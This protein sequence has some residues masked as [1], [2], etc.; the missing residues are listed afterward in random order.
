LKDLQANQKNIF[1]HKLF[2][3]GGLLLVIVFLFLLNF[4]SET[5]F[6]RPSSIHQWRQAD[7]LSIAK[8]YYE[9]GMH[10]FSPK[11]HSFLAPE[12]KAV[13]EFPLINYTVALLWK[14]FG[15]HE[16]IYRL[17]NYFIYLI[18]IFTLFNT[19]LRFFTSTPS[20][21]LYFVLS[22]LLTSPLLVYY[23]LNFL[24]DVP[25]LSF[26][27]LAFCFLFWFYQTKKISYFYLSLLFGTLAILLKASALMGLVMLSFVSII[28]LLKL[29]SFF[30]LEKLFHRKV[31]PSLLIPLSILLVYKWYTFALHYCAFDNGVFL[32]TVAPVWKMKE[33]AI[34][35]ILRQLF[36][37]L[38]PTFLNRPMFTLFFCCVLF[39]AFNLKKV[40]GLLRYSF[41]F[42]GLFFVLFIL[43]FFQVFTVHDYYLINLFIFVIVTLFCL[44][45]IM[46]QLDFKPNRYLKFT[47]PIL[48]IFNAFYAA[49]EYRLKTI[50]DD[51]LCAWY[52]FISKDE[53]NGASY[54]FWSYERTLK[55]FEDIQTDLRKLG[56]QRKDIFVNV[57]DESPNVSLYFVDQKGYTFSYDH[58]SRDSLC[59]E[60]LMGRKIQ[61]LAFTDTSLLNE[62]AFTRV[63]KSFEPILEKNHLSVFKRK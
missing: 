63:S 62:K 5:L 8:N 25:A 31:L 33:A 46:S 44:L 53:R 19:F 18:A 52:P 43:V 57:V 6:Y 50:K 47:L 29:N 30:K 51:K 35:D 36:N 39:V 17:L 49:A 48:I 60:K 38:F 37:N 10:F 28:D 59:I 56:I 12:G 7:C 34:F 3:N 21:Y 55:P 2:L 41:I 22:L 20:L 9:D 26:N 24:S 40:N 4:Y 45:E 16:F 54:F 15:E 42:S 1:Q 61:Y 11:I 14:V 13:S 23:S 27:I 32:L 58:F